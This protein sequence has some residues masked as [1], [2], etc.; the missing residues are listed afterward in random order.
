MLG[1]VIPARNEAK[2]ISKLINGIKNTGI[3]TDDIFVSNS[4]S[5]DKTEEIAKQLGCQIINVRNPGYTNAIVEGLKK[6][7]SL[8]YSKFLIIDGDNEISPNIIP[9]TLEHLRD[10]DLIFGQRKEI[11]R[12]G[13]KIV[14]FFYYRKYKINDYL[15]GY[16]AGNISTINFESSLEYCIDLFFH[17]ELNDTKIYNIPV[18]LNL[19]KETRLGNPLIVNIKLLIE[20]Y[21]LI[22][23]KKL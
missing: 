10:F 23:L 9:K 1:I 19:R 11:K 2:N 21:R 16:K 8:G 20:L 17:N 6:I 15:C 7:K 18:E 4:V 13:E 5:T 12:I 14:N 3:N 22:H